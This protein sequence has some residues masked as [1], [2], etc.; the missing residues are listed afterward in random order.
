M[1]LGIRSTAN[2]G[3]PRQEQWCW[4]AGDGLYKWKVTD[5]GL[6][7][8]KKQ[9]LVCLSFADDGHNYYFVQLVYSMGVCLT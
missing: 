8:K 2:T 7:F 1:I 9:G 5:G 6:V 4:W 3:Q